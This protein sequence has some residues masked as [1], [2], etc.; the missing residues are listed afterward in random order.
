LILPNL[1]E[2]LAKLEPKLAE[3]D[4]DGA[5]DAKAGEKKAVEKRKR[6][7]RDARRVHD[8]LKRAVGTCLHAALAVPV[9]AQVA[10]GEPEKRAARLSGKGKEPTVLEAD[11]RVCW[12]IGKN[13]NTLKVDVGGRSTEISID[14]AMIGGDNCEDPHRV[15]AAVAAAAAL[16]GDCVVPYAAVPAAAGAFL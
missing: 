6:R 3:G 14:N 8:L 7:Q 15:T 16:L 4:G 10:A 1:K 9:S 11:T 5:K 12:K 2:Y 13:P